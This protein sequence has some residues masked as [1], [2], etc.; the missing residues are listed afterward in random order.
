MTKH[1]FKWTG[2]VWESHIGKGQNR[3]RVNIAAREDDQESV[4]ALAS[5]AKTFNE[6]WDENKEGLCADLLAWCERS[7][8]SPML[9]AFKNAEMSTGNEGWT[10][11]RYEH[12]RN[13]F[14]DIMVQFIDDNGPVW[15][16]ELYVKITGVLED[17]RFYVE[18][19]LSF[20][21]ISF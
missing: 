21:L 16:D 13:V 20:E 4:D 9:R 6:F 1:E 7:G 17:D 5:L 18:D 19:K 8:D 15:G 12:S 3:R 14:F 2:L 10:L 11:S